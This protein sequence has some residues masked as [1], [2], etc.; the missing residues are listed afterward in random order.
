MKNIRKI[1]IF[2]L[3]CLGDT[4]FI[5]P[6]IINLKKNFPDAKIYLISS[7]WISALKGI[8]PDIDEVITYNPPFKG[9]ILTKIF[10]AIKLIRLLRKEKFDLVFL[11]HRTSYFGLILMLSGIPYRF[12][13][14]VTKFLN[15]T[16]P[17]DFSKPE[18]LRYLDVLESNGIK[19]YT[20][21]PVLKRTKTKEELRIKLGLPLDKKIVGIFAFGGVNPGTQM[22][23]KRWDI[24][25][26]E[27]LIGMIE[28]RFE[29]QAGVLMVEGT[30]DDEKFET[31]KDFKY[32]YNR[33]IDFEDLLACD[34]FICGDTGLLHIAAAFEIPTIALFGPTAPIMYAPFQ[35]SGTPHV[36]IWKKPWCSPCHTPE[37]AIAKS[38]NKYWDGNTFKCFTGTLECMKAITEEEVFQ[39][40]KNIIGI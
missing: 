11:G 6:A 14:S 33:K 36:H 25:H 32:T 17:Y 39:N 29:G 2:K 7:G 9:G 40:I 23:I 4:I 31:K 34:V 10:S 38:N 30:F 19:I 3:C 22:R 1:L 21:Q 15:R 16:A 5:T 28:D 35:T 37:T 8:L 26:Y 24:R 12:G 13:F 20:H 27:N 18:V